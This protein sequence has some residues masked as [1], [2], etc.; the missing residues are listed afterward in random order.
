MGITGATFTVLGA[1]GYIGSR[2]VT[3]LKN[4]GHECQS[5][6][7][8]DPLPKTL[9]HVVFCIGLTSDFRTRIFD[10]VEAHVSILTEYIR[11]LR[12]ESFLYLSSAR[13]YQG[14]KAEVAEETADLIVNPNNTNDIYNISKLM[15]EALCL[16]QANP[17][18][19][20]VRLSNV[21]GPHDTSQNFLSSVANSCVNSGEVILERVHSLPRT[22]FGST[23][24]LQL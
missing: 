22:I 14:L 6:R 2:L 20:V 24:L 5:V 10:T 9:G 13:V 21:F 1:S 4:H 16:A 18:V 11:N 3:H 7:R 17:R 19:R 23:M 15:G 8:S 12:Y